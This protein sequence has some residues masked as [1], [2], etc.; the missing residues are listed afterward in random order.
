MLMTL[1]TLTGDFFAAHQGKLL[2]VEAVNGQL[3]L[4]VMSVEET[5]QSAGPNSKR[6]PFRVLLR[7][8][9]SPCLE[10]GCY[11]FRAN[12]DENW[13]LED[14]YINRIIAPANSDGQGAFY[15]IVFS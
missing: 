2:T 14:I 1:A 5:P 13:R 8:P 11:S 3:T 7:G 10:D 12:D 4:E 6:T 9:D 15:Q